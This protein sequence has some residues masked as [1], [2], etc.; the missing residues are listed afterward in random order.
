[1]SCSPTAKVST[2]N[3]LAR[4]DFMH[5]ESKKEGESNESAL[6]EL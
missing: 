1:V 6:L 2:D 3:S 5:Q 4:E